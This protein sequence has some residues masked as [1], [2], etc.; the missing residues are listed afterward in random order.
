MKIVR[1]F[2][3]LL[4]ATIC[5]AGLAACGGG[6][7]NSDPKKLDTPTGLVLH[8]NGLLEWTA[9]NGAWG[10]VV[11]ATAENNASWS[12][13]I[14]SGDRTE[15]ALEF[16]YLQ[17]P[18]IYEL[19]VKASGKESI[20]LDS[21]WSVLPEKYAKLPPKPSSQGLTIEYYSPSKGYRVM[22]KGTCTDAYIVIPFTW[23][24]SIGFGTQMVKSIGE[25][26]FANDTTITGIEMSMWVIQIGQS[27]FA[28]CTNITEIS[29]PNGCIVGA[30]AFSGWTD[31]QTIR[32]LGNTN[33]WS[34]NW[35]AGCNAI[36]IN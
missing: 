3:V 29:I 32:I 23:S 18:E 26:A 16:M 25:N 27:A 22:N 21:D 28:G 15:C 8:S 34:S 9:V 12:K 5:V 33:G 10:Y 7:K 2:A 30:N 36:I 13:E 20:C 6:A 1:N 19:R 17:G 35:N 4:L 14:S 24:S 11:S 31:A